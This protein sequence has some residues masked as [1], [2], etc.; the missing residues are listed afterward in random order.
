MHKIPQSSSMTLGTVKQFFSK[1]TLLS[2]INFRS[3]RSSPLPSDVVGTTFSQEEGRGYR[4]GSVM[5]DRK[6]NKRYASRDYGL[7]CG[8]DSYVCIEENV[9]RGFVRRT[10]SA[11]SKEFEGYSTQEQTGSINLSNTLIKIEI[12]LN[13]Q[14]LSARPNARKSIDPT[15]EQTRCK[16]PSG[17]VPSGTGRVKRIEERAI[18]TTA[19]SVLLND[20]DFKVWM[21]VNLAI[22]FYDL[23]LWRILQNHTVQFI[24]WNT[25]RERIL[26]WSGP[27]PV[28]Q[29]GKPRRKTKE[30]PKKGRR[31]E[32]RINLVKRE[33]SRR[34][35]SIAKQRTPME[36]LDSL[37]LDEWVSYKA[38]V[39]DKLINLL[40]QYLKK[41]HADTQ[42]SGGYMRPGWKD[43]PTVQNFHPISQACHFLAKFV[44][45]Y[46]AKRNTQPRLCVPTMTRP[47]S[48][49]SRLPV[50]CM[51]TENVFSRK[52]RKNGSSIKITV[53]IDEV[54]RTMK[55]SC[56]NL[57]F[58][59]HMLLP[60]IDRLL[61]NLAQTSVIMFRTQLQ[62]NATS[63]LSEILNRV[64]KPVV[65]SKDKGCW[66]TPE[67]K[68]P[69]R[70]PSA[71]RYTQPFA[72]KSQA[73]SPRMNF[74]P[75]QY[76]PRRAAPVLNVG[77]PYHRG[78]D[79]G[80]LCIYRTLK[81]KTWMMYESTNFHKNVNLRKNPQNLQNLQLLENSLNPFEC[82]GILRPFRTDGRRLYFTGQDG[83]I[84]TKRQPIDG[85][86]GGAQS[87]SVKL[88]HHWN[89][90]YVECI[91]MYV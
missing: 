50:L 61:Q 30:E 73:S 54:C 2:Y 9:H 58:L 25:V 18:A 14:S 62:H 20:Q 65:A 31:P 35:C 11:E 81:D 17:T 32:R 15:S 64:T 60:K 27:W 69:P 39:W 59:K 7:V 16:D 91:C 56:F 33:R 29:G 23:V 10:W 57:M 12:V 19:S 38:K 3:V 22:N 24:R 5:V 1:T 6:T 79:C 83:V 4:E 26:R 78:Q 71:I 55:R 86:G 87:A 34:T 70:P 13:I 76:D 89:V 44:S 48:M 42:G 51:Q 52:L 49:V 74:N 40:T 43:K 66:G 85:S 90:V 67:L 53:E 21:N 77:N 88:N 63:P 41:S 47:T 45:V 8:E 80:F 28:D 46:G 36:P 68:P 82:R 84:L 72:I 75:E 37:A